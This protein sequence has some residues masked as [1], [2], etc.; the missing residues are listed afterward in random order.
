MRN[1]FAL[2]LL[3]VCTLVSRVAMAS[4]G[5]LCHASADPIV[6]DGVLNEPAWQSVPR[7]GFLGLADGGSPPFPCGVRLVW[8]ARYLYLAF[9]IDTPDV[10]AT[11]GDDVPEPRPGDAGQWNKFLMTRDC[12]AKVFLDPDGDGRDYVEMHINP[13]NNVD[14]VWIG[15]GSTSP[16]RQSVDFSPS[17]YHLEWDCPGL[18]S[19]VRVKGTLNQRSD[20]DEGWV[21]EMEIPWDALARFTVGP[22]PPVPGDVWRGHFGVETRS[23]PGASSACYAWPVIG[24]YDCHQLGRYGYIT[25]S[26]EP[27]AQ[28]VEKTR[29][30]PPGRT[31]VWKAARCAGRLERSPGEVAQAARSLGFTV[32]ECADVAM[33]EACHCAGLKA[34]G[35][36]RL[37]DASQPFRQ[38]VLPRERALAAHRDERPSE[39]SLDQA[40]YEPLL[41]GGLVTRA[42]PWCLQSPEAMAHARRQ[43]DRLLADGCDVIALE[44]VGYRNGYACFCDI[45]RAQQAEYRQDHPEMAPA[46]AVR[47]HSRQR[48]ITFCNELVAYAHSRQPGVVVACRD[49][50][51]FGPD[52]LWVGAVDADVRVVTVARIGAINRAKDKGTR[53][54][55]EIAALSLSAGKNRTTAGYIEFS[56]ASAVESVNTARQEMKEALRI[57]LEEGVLAVEIGDLTAILRDP[58]MVAIVREALTGM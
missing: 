53:Y 42:N 49:W 25:F 17:N 5:Y 18:R 15:V 22:C 2:L 20:R 58:S 21:L 14:D 47:A 38:V 3:L 54:V 43:I 56:S 39:D 35:V 40:G 36:V 13:L 8:D 52:P 33:V 1:W 32:L 48:L 4:P 6:V 55:R 28:L 31:L 34:L 16:R 45:C 46:Q 10:W 29:H 50:P 19:A 11:A 7:I 44:A 27:A 9:E 23:H 30:S 57:M 24:L 51:W 37:D 12:F 26:A 41:G